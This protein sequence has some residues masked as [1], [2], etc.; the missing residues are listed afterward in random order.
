MVVILPLGEMFGCILNHGKL[1]HCGSAHYPD[2][3]AYFWVRNKGN[4][5]VCPSGKL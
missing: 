3:R 5:V 1:P 4:L 2:L